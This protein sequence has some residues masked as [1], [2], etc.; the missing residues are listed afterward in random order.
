MPRQNLF[1]TA[2]AIVL[3]ACCAACA[4]LRAGATSPRPIQDVVIVSLTQIQSAER[5]YKAM[6]GG[7][8]GSFP[9]LVSAGLLDSRFLGSHAGHN[10]VLTATG[11]SYLASATPA[12]GSGWRYSVSDSDAVVRIESYPGSDTKRNVAK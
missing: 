10:F 7:N 9:E 1:L 5:S 4:A 8:Y 11:S 6:S 12:S 2:L 3:S